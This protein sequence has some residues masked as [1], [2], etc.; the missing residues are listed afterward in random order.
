LIAATG[1]GQAPIGPG[2]RWYYQVIPLKWVALSGSSEELPRGYQG[3]LR[4]LSD[5]LV[6]KRDVM[7]A[8]HVLVAAKDVT[9]V[10]AWVYIRYGKGNVN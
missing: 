8:C 6:P 9:Q 2:V 3:T 5:F 10:A 7:I 4:S 1:P